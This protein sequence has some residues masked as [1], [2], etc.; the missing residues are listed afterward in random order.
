MNPFL[1]SAVD[2]TIMW[3]LWLSMYHLAIVSV[4]DELHLFQ[5]LQHGPLSIND[6][7]LKLNINPRGVE[8]LFGALTGMKLLKKEAE[9][10]RL[11]PQ[12]ERYLI[13]ESPFY[14]GE[15]LHQT[16]EQAEHKALLIAI[17]QGRNPFSLYGRLSEDW[18]RNSLSAE[19]AR[20]FTGLMHSIIFAPALHAVQSGLFGSVSKLLDV[21]G[22]SGCF[23]IGFVKTYP[24]R[25]SGIFD[26]PAVCEISREYIRKFT[27]EHQVQI[28]PG[29]FFTD[30]WPEG[31]DGFCFS[32]I[33]HD[34]APQQCQQ[35]ADSAYEA[36]E[37]GGRIFLHEMLLNDDRSTPLTTALF[38]VYMFKDF[39][40][41]QHTQAELTDILLK[42]GFE[43]PS[44]TPALG[45]YSVLSAGKPQQV[46]VS[47]SESSPQHALKKAPDRVKE[48][49]AR[50]LAFVFSGMG[51]Q[52]K[53]MGQQ[54]F[55]QEE[56]FRNMIE[57]CDQRFQRFASWSITEE[58][59]KEPS[60]LEESKI[61][62]PC[63]LAVQLALVALYNTWGITPDGILGHSCGEVAAAYTAGVLSLEHCLQVLW[64]HQQCME[65][66]QRNGLMAHI[67]LPAQEVSEILH[68]YEKLVVVAAINSP[69][70]TVISGEART[71]ATIVTALVSKGTFCRIM[72]IDL[73][74]HS[75][76]IKP[77]DIIVDAI[78]PSAAIIPL[79]S[80]ARGD[81]SLTGDYDTQYWKRH[82]RRPVL[83]APA[84]EAMLRDGY[85]VFLEIGP[86]PVLSASINACFQKYDTQ[87]CVVM[88]SLKRAEDEKDS[89]LSSLAALYN[90]G[91]Q[92][93]LEALKETD[94]ERFNSCV[95]S[96]QEESAEDET[97]LVQ[98]LKQAFPPQRK[99][100]LLMLIQQIVERISE[101]TIIPFDPQTGFLEMGLTSLMAVHL[102]QQLSSHLHLSLSSTLMFDHPTMEDLAVYLESQ[103]LGEDLENTPALNFYTGKQATGQGDE[104]IAV[105]GMACRFPGGANSPEQYWNLL[106]QGADAVCEIPR[107]R[108]DVDKFYDPNP[109]VPGK[110]ITRQGGF[111]KD[112]DLEAFDA[113]FFQISPI[114][115][116]NLDPQQRLL[117][118]VTYEAFENAGLPVVDLKDQL[119]GV[120]VGMCSFDFTS[121]V[122]WNDIHQINVYS[123]TGSFFS[124]ATGR[125]SYVLNLHGPNFPIDTACSSSLVAIDTACRSLRAQTSDVAI[126]GGVNLLL[127]PHLFI[128]F[129]KLGA[130]S[131]DG[132]CKT[133]DA[134]ANGY[135]RGEGCG[136]IVLK[137][138][139]A[140]LAA[141]DRVLALIRGSAV[142]HDGQSSSFTAP[143]GT[144]QKNVIHQALADA[145]L[146]P[147]QISYVDA[148]GTGTPLGDPIEVNALGAVYG[149]S[150]TQERPLI[151]GSAKANIGHLEGA[152][153]IAGVIKII[154]ALNHHAIPPQVHFNTP[155]PHIPWDT[156]P[157]Q[158]PTTLTP[159]LRGQES[160]IAG[161]NSFGFSGTNA[162]VII[163][164][165]PLDCRLT[166]D[167]CRLKDSDLEDSEQANNHQPS[168]NN[169][170]S[171]IVNRQCHL[172][173]LSAR[174]QEA[175]KDLVV[176]FQA[177]LATTDARLADICYTANVGRR[178]FPVRYAVSGN[179]KAEL[180]NRLAAWAPETAPTPQ[181]TSPKPHQAPDYLP[182][183]EEIAKHLDPYLKASV[184]KIQFYTEL[185]PQIESLCIVYVL[186]TLEHLGWNWQRNQRFSTTEMIRQLGIIEQHHKL[187]TRLL[188]MLSEENILV[189]V[190]E[191]RWEVVSIPE[192][193]DP[194]KQINELAVCYPE[195]QSELTLLEQCGPVLHTLLQ[196]ASDP[197]QIL[198]PNGDFMLLTQFYQHA[199][200]NRFMNTLVQQAISVALKSVPQRRKIRILEIG[201]GTGSTT[202]YLLPELPKEQTEYLFTDV[203]A[204][205]VQAARDRFTEYPFV[206]YQPFDLENDPIA[207]GFDNQGYDIIL[208]PH[209]L[210]ATT[211]L[212]TS[213][214]HVYRL[215]AP[216]G[217]LV[218]LESTGKRRWLDL[219]FGLLKGWWHFRDRELRPSYPLLP[220]DQWQSLLS[221]HGFSQ[222]TCLSP[223]DVRD[224]LQLEQ[225]LIIAQ[226]PSLVSP[227][228]LRSQTQSKES[229]EVVM[230]F[231]GQGSQYPGMGRELYE[232][233]PVF[234][235]ALEQCD[236]Y[237]KP[238]LNSSIIELLYAT[239]GPDHASSINQTIHTQPT[240]FSIEYALSQL[241]R[242]WGVQ[243]AAV[244]GHSIGEYVAACVSGVFSLED[245]VKLVANRATL[246]QSLP[247]GGMMAVVFADEA[248]VRQAIN[249]YEAE[250]SVAAVNA[251]NNLVISGVRT[252]VELIVTALQE[253]GIG[254]RPLNVS[255]AFH[256][257]QMAP[258][259]S[260][261]QEIASQITY[262]SPSLPVVSNVSGTWASGT[263]LMNA[264]YW[265][266]HIR[267]AVRFADA[268]YTFDQAGYQT[269]LEVG[270]HPTLTVLGRHCLADGKQSW[271]SSLK[272][273]QKNWQ[274]ILASLGGLYRRG[275]EIDWAG[276]DSPYSRHKVSLPTYPFQRQ[277][278][279]MPA[280]LTA[281][282]T[283]ARIIS[284]GEHP[285]IGRKI[286]SPALQDTI[287]FETV[288][289]QEFPDFL[290]EHR[291]YEKIISPAAAHMAMV[292]AGGHLVFHSP[293][294]TIEEVS[295]IRPLILDEE[296]ERTVQLILKPHE[297]TAWSFRIISAPVLSKV[298]GD[299]ADEEWTV[300]CE[301]RVSPDCESPPTEE[302]SI[303]TLKKRCPKHTDGRTF[304][305]RFAQAG[306]DLGP[307]FQAIQDAW[308]G[309]FEAVTRLK[310]SDEAVNT[311]EGRIHPGLIDSIFQS[312]MFTAL[313]RLD[314]IILKGN[315]FIPYTL[316]R[317]TYTGHSFTGRLW[318]HASS[319]SGEDFLD[320]DLRVWNEDGQL[321]FN[322]QSLVVKETKRES[323]LK[324]IHGSPIQELVYA[325][326]W[327]AQPGPSTSL[328]TGDGDS[329]RV[330]GPCLI[331][332]DRQ[333]MGEQLAGVLKEQQVEVFQVFRGETFAQYDD[334][335]LVI[336]PNVE[337][338]VHQ[339]FEHYERLNANPP[340]HILFLW[341]LDSSLSEEQSSRELEQAI[342]QSCG[343]LL[344]VVKT[345]AAFQWRHYPRLW[346]VTRQAH[347]IDAEQP[348]LALCQGPLWGLGRVI[349]L[350]HPEL[351]GTCLDLNDVSAGIQRLVQ[352]LALN[353]R[354]YQVA[355]RNGSRYVARF[356]HRK[357]SAQPAKS[358][359]ISPRA[360][361]LI[362]GGLG[363][364]GMLAAGWL[365]EKGARS[366]V[367]IGRR[368]PKPEVQQQIE[369]F[370]QQGVRVQLEQCDIADESALADVFARIQ[371]SLLP[372][373]GILHAAGVLDDGMLLQ[374]SWPRFQRVMTGKVYGAW[375]LHRLTQTQTLDFF[376][377][378]SSLSSLLGNH[379]QG[380]YAAAN[381]F[382]D[383]LAHYRQKHGLAG[384]SI[385]WALWGVS[386]SMA[387]GAEDTLHEWGVTAFTPEEAFHALERILEHDLI[388]TG[389]MRCDWVKY[390]AKLHG[391]GQIGVLTNLL[392]EK[393]KTE[394]EQQVHATGS[395]DVRREIENAAP[396]ERYDLLVFHLRKIVADIIGLSNKN[397]VEIARPFME[398]GV[399]SLMAVELRGHLSKL[400]EVPLPASFFFTY[401]T[402]KEAANYL[403]TEIFS[404]DMSQQTE[405]A[406]TTDILE[407]LNS[408]LKR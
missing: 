213:L 339:V 41:Q 105:V 25:Q 359:P 350:E 154:L 18:E 79:Y 340:T 309:E 304:H 47:V 379:G 35:L 219:T 251:P 60:R 393:Q 203:S 85:T 90:T 12:A 268:I 264:G 286:S 29:N 56:V 62:N 193:K 30:P 347:V 260:Q 164:E 64:Y 73:P 274:T 101:Q 187:F 229:S 377:M 139:S 334:G 58:L 107:D 168:I 6:L 318:T 65:L 346:I 215:L 124:C 325:M 128:N 104:P 50:K 237:F 243:P 88:P 211:S 9:Q 131:P 313:E 38:D 99:Q 230:L 300:H 316:D 358:L 152:A 352:E 195:A 173:S 223:D 78:C 42:A 337:K 369:K 283:S 315:V 357:L 401:P 26:L 24:E 39:S 331:F 282:R 217:L 121:N 263:D 5:E 130:I 153:G 53:Q 314:D 140:A 174:S 383:A 208:L 116:R 31:Y 186:Q 402:V 226:K 256:S 48:A 81:L 247:E 328:R 132:R 246:M 322:V 14:W 172:L 303:E 151:V 210:H 280:C 374:Q 13:P 278:Y 17:R 275:V 11:T 332:S 182:S 55:Q 185:S 294:C 86:H 93:D 212:N 296:H 353:T 189:S 254:A 235:Q 279:K 49:S 399:D 365:V 114:E 111:L 390:A 201:A 227:V 37:P 188:E 356:N 269:F 66:V 361:Y 144:A 397:Q 142:N 156:L 385:N 179:S 43:K 206:Q 32:N 77:D 400:F 8:A 292:I 155:N 23:S 324:A 108:F 170:Q 392:K 293:Q 407:K 45:Y 57:Q 16:R 261:F 167:D 373:K 4:A 83:F 267:E 345:L 272:R 341:G 191:N 299:V 46:L 396:E 126:A 333:G 398:Q 344:H 200:N 1:V 177:Y 297:G 281:A 391:N 405:K 363:V 378:F 27:V 295:F 248:L 348:S 119:V 349:A 113:R 408:L 312:G 2:D 199:P 28:Y 233:Q 181:K 7:S 321:L 158:I 380:N 209:V 69:N 205:F 242:S 123:T 129:S 258:I 291:V 305:E 266:R 214:E 288:F 147:E 127:N 135:G 96:I 71:V 102:Q 120:Y 259:L 202:A 270:A 329:A 387:E 221:A 262:Q 98:E 366:L 54:L 91:Y 241:W 289:D 284:C 376:V 95:T 220:A 197:L 232:T 70:T 236:E 63:I 15:L 176:K 207:Q 406:T 371:Q 80:S 94:R 171:S 301:G 394:Q 180:A 44:A 306:Y 252:A 204:L 338:E 403:L 302:N 159:W 273:G 196:G 160:R 198:F 61:A 36:L 178:H 382:L 234:R 386:G 245:A 84:I 351:R 74:F 117:L 112:V 163:E 148:H 89:L 166:I 161:I 308:S 364:L 326:E 290:Q 149:H 106:S 22:G 20:K 319:R 375:N 165:A 224:S 51:V 277:K 183:A 336:N 343:S 360:T 238:H 367:L 175:L 381:A 330:S 110:I 240:I 250:V 21:G 335:T 384:T 190:D 244:A 134:T 372:V 68:S 231:T 354:D 298:E 76:V 342:E 271:L 310:S 253:Q 192:I 118:E 33:F 115:A 103:I 109:D 67:G 228:Q 157:I 368:G 307:N 150:H 249:G 388:Q 216:H 395:E 169:Q 141:G 82:I 276:F 320:N 100:K 225:A 317:L 222:I 34:W 370:R 239:P 122:L 194:Q 136:V 97:Q 72:D 87:R 52:W 311:K 404:S 362:T 40:A 138:L 137:R 255:H 285:Y 133:F 287:I 10:L 327:E 125:L 389:V 146:S 184:Q 3:D 355:L 323:L 92:V 59:F 265:T 218:C 143:N 75:P 19:A 257:P 145:S 162:H